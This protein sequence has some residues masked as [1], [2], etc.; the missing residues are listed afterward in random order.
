MTQETP[1]EKSLRFL[2]RVLDLGAPYREAMVRSLRQ[3]ADP[4][5]VAELS[6]ICDEYDAILREIPDG[7]TVPDPVMVRQ[8]L[9]DILTWRGLARQ[10]NG[11]LKAAVADYE[12]ATR[13]FDEIGHTEQAARARESIARLR[14]DDEGNVDE[15]I[16]RLRAELRRLTPGTLP[17]VRAQI[18][19]GEL[20][21]QHGDH[22]EARKH[23]APAE[24]ALLVLNPNPTESNILEDL[25]RSITAIE[26]GQAGDSETIPVVSAMELRALYQR[27][28]FAL[29]RAYSK[30]DP[31][32]SAEYEEKLKA[33]SKGRRSLTQEQ[34][35]QLAG[36][37]LSIADLKLEKR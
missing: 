31:S 12:R 20:Y 29:A 10:K 2:T 11:E 33:F 7:A 13:I 27:L 3:S 15:E 19:L 25:F 18:M 17:H 26:S 16:E 1:T 28:Y 14:L 5:L 8:Q 23:L 34:L 4:G 37:K 6:R 24:A 30:S 35:E 32:K 9:A 21:T 36:G 22:F